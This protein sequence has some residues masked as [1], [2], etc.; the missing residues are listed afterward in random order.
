AKVALADAPA[1][2]I[3]RRGA[4]S[5]EVAAAL[6]DGAIARFG[7]DLGIGITGIAGPDGGTPEKPVGTVCL[8]VAAR[9]GS[10]LERTVRLPGDRAAIRERTTTVTLHLLRRVLI[11]GGAVA[12][13]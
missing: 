4:V 3:E 1:A 9:D 5:P 11:A 10:R 12:A 2:L 6:A 13:A 7:A 8:C